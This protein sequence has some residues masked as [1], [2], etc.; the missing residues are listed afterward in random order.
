[1]MTSSLTGVLQNSWVILALSV[2]AL[3]VSV[4]FLI[5]SRRELAGRVKEIVTLQRDIRAIT[6]AAIGVG[7]R[8]LEL[9]RRQKR[10]TERQDT[11]DIYDPANQPYE[12]AIRMVQTGSDVTELVDICGLSESEAELITLMHRLDK[13]A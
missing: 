9:E 1:M 7:E 10:L 4:L 5:R 11:M 13:T 3:L 6:A 2:C 8:V 12:Q